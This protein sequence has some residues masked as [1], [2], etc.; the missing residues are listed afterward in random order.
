VVRENLEKFGEICEMAGVF[1]W[2]EREISPGER[3]E[4][5]SA[6]EVEFAGICGIAG[7][8]EWGMVECELGRSLC[9]VFICR[10]FVMAAWIRRGESRGGSW[11]ELVIARVCGGNVD[12]NGRK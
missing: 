7:V 12:C 3:L 10:I 2:R 8:F 5:S 9:G 11:L 6:S 1:A 4:D